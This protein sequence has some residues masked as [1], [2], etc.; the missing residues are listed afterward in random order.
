MPSLATAYSGPPKLTLARAFTEW[1]G[2]V[3]MLVLILLL[4]A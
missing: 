1:R 2:P 3:P 4:A